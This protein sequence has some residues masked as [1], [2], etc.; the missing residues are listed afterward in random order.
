MY[1][2]RYALSVTVG[3]VM[4]L[5]GLSD[6]AERGYVTEGTASFRFLT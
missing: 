5:W 3:I 2:C 1:P 4:L 6:P